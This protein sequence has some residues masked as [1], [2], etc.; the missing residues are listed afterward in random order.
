MMKGYIQTRTMLNEE[1]GPNSPP[2][3]QII[4]LHFTIS[5]SP[6]PPHNSQDHLQHNNPNPIHL[7]LINLI[8]LIH[9]ATQLRRPPVKQ[10][11]VQLTV[12]GLELVVF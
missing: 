1:E 12:T 2:N 5:S 11:K 4:N 7:R 9:P 8:I 3:M 6:F 10:I